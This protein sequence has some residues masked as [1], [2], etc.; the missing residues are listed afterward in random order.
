M[1]FITLTTHTRTATGG[2]ATQDWD[3]V[4]HAAASDRKSSAVTTPP[5]ACLI[6]ATSSHDGIVSPR[7]TRLMVVRSTRAKAAK[8]SSVSP[9]DDIHSLSF[10]PRISAL[11]AR[12]CQA[13]G[14][15][16]AVDSKRGCAQHAHM[17]NVTKP[18]PE[19]QN[20]FVKWRK[21]RRLRQ[22]DVAEKT[23]WDRTMISKIESGEV[24]FTPSSLEAL[25]NVYQCT[26]GAL[27]DRDPFT[28]EPVDISDLSERDQKLIID[29]LQRFRSKE[30]EDAEIPVAP[31]VR[32]AGRVRK[33]SKTMAAS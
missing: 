14:A 5:L 6:D 33:H 8:R 9:S 22:E 15:S 16:N 26:R 10:I 25:S 31:R 13:L 24:A 19:K 20:Y 23:G 17:P 27:L 29:M 1:R 11:D 28:P 12:A 30:S 21:F 7:R 32:L 3:C 4:V 2:D 18:I